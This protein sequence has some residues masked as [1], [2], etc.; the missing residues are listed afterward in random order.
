L[1]PTENMSDFSV[2]WNRLISKCIMFLSVLIPGI[3][4]LKYVDKRPIAILGIGIYKGALRELSVGMLI[5]FG[6][7]TFTVFIIW[8]IG[9]A[10]FSFNGFSADL[11][12]Y[13]V[14]VLI[15]LIISASYD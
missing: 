5:G 14:C 6:L 8:L 11:I 3:V 7:I 2:L 12:Q 4:L 9:A 10:A 13:V 15:V 1:I